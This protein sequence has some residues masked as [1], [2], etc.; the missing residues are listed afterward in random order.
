MARI[1]DNYYERF[2]K[3][4]NKV[5]SI[6][7]EIAARFVGLKELLLEDEASIINTLNDKLENNRGEAYF[8]L[9]TNDMK[10]FNQ[11]TKA[12]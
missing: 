12:K 6:F 7:N 1:L 3:D 11:L 4:W 5:S 10:T 8:A 2:N 9:M